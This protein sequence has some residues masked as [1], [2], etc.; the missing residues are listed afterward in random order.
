M[1]RNKD[2]SR[3]VAKNKRVKTRVQRLFLSRLFLTVLLVLIQIG[4]FSFFANILNDYISVIFGLNIFLSLLFMIYLTNCKGKNEFKIAWLIPTIFFPILGISLYMITHMNWGG[5]SFKKRMKKVKTESVKFIP[6][7]QI[8]EKIIN[9]NPDIASISKYLLNKGNFA[10]HTNNNVSYFRNGESF[11]EDLLVELEKAKEFIFIEFFIIDLDESWLKIMSILE[12]KVKEGVEVRLLY[13]AIG[14]IIMSSRSYQNL[15][16]EKGIKSHIF[17]KLLPLYIVK[18]NNRDHRKIVVID[19][20]V[21]YTGG[22]NV[23]NKYFNQ[24]PHKFKYWKD[25]SIKILG[26]AIQNLT[27]LFL[28]NWN[29]ETKE[30]DDYEKYIKRD[31]ELYN[32]KGVV[33]PYGDD[34]F[35]DEDIAE[36]VYLHILNT[37]TKYVHIMTPYVI[38]DNQMVESLCFAAARGIDVTII[39]PPVPDHLI[40]FCVG[41]I[42]QKIL[43]EAGVKIYIYQTGFIHAKQFISDDKLLSIGSIN[44]DYRSF[45]HH[46]ECNSIVYNNKT[47]ND[48]ETDFQQTLSE[49]ILLTPELYKKIPKWQLVLGYIFRIVGPLM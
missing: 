1:R 25:T 8:S 3:V 43:M 5:I 13:D 2:Y 7:N 41:K 37:A 49:S 47:V 21:S 12:R 46:F 14:S 30:D 48:A 26:P 22:V 4:V 33:I 29:L 11:F 10:P 31:Y 9:N 15:L 20:K 35:N 18:L 17:Q 28:Q 16:K 32:D 44:L 6:D 36:N 39:C 40:S 45:Y 24:K 42:Y 19:G 34:A 23:T 38:I 27:M